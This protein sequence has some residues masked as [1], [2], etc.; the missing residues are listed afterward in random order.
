MVN[1]EEYR[2]RII[3][4]SGEIFS[5]YGFKKTSMEEIAEA[6]KMGKS[7]I[8]YYFGEGSYL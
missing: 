5:R 8:Y 2:K 3:V 7:S 1:K 4:T 6:L